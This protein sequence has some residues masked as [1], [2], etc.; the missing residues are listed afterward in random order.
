MSKIT[1]GL[2]AAVCVL[3]L[4]SGGLFWW[5]LSLRDERA[6]LEHQLK[7]TQESLSAQLSAQRAGEAG[8]CEVR[9]KAQEKASQLTLAMCESR[10]QEVEDRCKLREEMR[11]DPSKIVDVFEDVLGLSSPDPSP[12]DA[13]TPSP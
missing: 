12:D 7:T 13:T 8:R 6:V 11:D 5:V 10:V 3:A 9:L 2:I 1:M 4:T